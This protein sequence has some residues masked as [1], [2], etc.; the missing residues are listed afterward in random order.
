MTKIKTM[1][2][3]VKEFHQVFKHPIG[4]KPSLDFYSDNPETNAKL[5]SL[6]VGLIREE[7]GELEDA[8]ADNDVVEVADALADLL[9]VVLGAAHCYGIPI[10]EVF[11]EVHSS[12]MSKLD[13]DGNPILREDGKILKGPNYFRPNITDII[14]RHK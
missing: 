1:T 12:N 8:I 2:D 6:R 14:E 11:N 13:A 5:H 10:D 9:Y 7:L 3:Q 4:T